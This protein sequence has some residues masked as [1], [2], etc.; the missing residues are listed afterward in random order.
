MFNKI[1]EF[2]DRKF[3]PVKPVPAGIYQYT[4]P[5][6]A[7]PPYKLH[8][9]V[10]EDGEGILIINARTVLH[11]NRT[12]AE[13]AYHLVQGKQP[14]EIRALEA[15][16][17]DADADQIGRDLEEFIGQINTLIATEDLDPVSYLNM[18]RVAPYSG[19]LSAPDRLDCALTYRVSAGTAADAAP[20]E[21]V[22]RELSTDEWKA[23][24]DKVWSAGI[25]HLNFT[26][27]EPTLRDDLADLIGHAEQLGIV[28]GL[29]TD[30]LRLADKKYAV[31]LLNKGLDHIMLLIQPERKEFWK[32]LANLMPENIAV[33]AHITVTPENKGSVND[34]LDKLS[35]QGVASISLSARDPSLA[36]ELE[37]A[38]QHA[39]HLG[40]QPTW[41]LPVPYSDLHPVAL[42]IQSAERDIPKG[43]GHAWLYVEP[44]GDVLPEQGV[45]RVLGNLLGD[46]WEKIWKKH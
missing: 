36:E 46:P 11:L 35:A 42:E 19:K 43:A 8:L 4:T 1:T 18:E 9:R 12:A 17:F 45:N 2:F 29:L 30:G 39:A 3:S 6:N 34:L 22:S 27:G 25:P 24:L 21:R 20:A 38:I 16:R 28:T 14:D 31:S 37:A 23:V 13:F 32:A 15:E 7:D 10:E 44:D 5:E 41:D 40:M 26:G 33:T